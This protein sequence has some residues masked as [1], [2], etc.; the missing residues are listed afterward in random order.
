MPTAVGN[1][2]WLVSCIVTITRPW[3]AMATADRAQLLHKVTKHPRPDEVNVMDGGFVLS[4]VQAASLGHFVLR[5]AGNRTARQNVLPKP[6]QRRRPAEYG[7]LVRL[8]SR[9]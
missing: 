1:G 3:R 2:E 7:E 8:L 4:E 9:T 6:K 5:M